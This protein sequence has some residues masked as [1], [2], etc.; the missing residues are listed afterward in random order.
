[1]LDRV[2]FSGLDEVPKASSIAAALH[3]KTSNVASNLTTKGKIQGLTSK[4]L[5]GKAHT[6]KSTL[7]FE[8][9]LAL[10]IYGLVFSPSIDGFVDAKAVQIFLTKNPVPTLLADT[11]HSI[12]HRTDKQGGTILCYA[13]LLYKWYTLHLPRLYLSK[14]KALYS[15]KIMSLAPTDVVWYN[16]TYDIGT[17]IDS[18]G[19]FANVALLGIHGGISYKPTLAKRPFGYP[20]KEKPRNIALES[21]FYH[22]HTDN[23]GM[24]DQFVKSWRTIQKKNNNQ[25]GDKSDLT[26]ETYTQWVIDRAVEYGMPYTL[27]R[28]LSSTTPKLPLPLPPNTQEKYQGK[29]VDLK[30]VCAT[31]KRKY[32]EAMSQVEDRDVEILQHKHELLDKERQLIE[33]NVQIQAQSARLAQFISRKECMDFFAGV[34]PDFEE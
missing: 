16:P 24:R 5:I 29:M 14:E 30:R 22:Y 26:Y 17:I 28:Y 11:Y 1:V 31:W 2:P 19:A 32:E 3:L 13:P 27:P 15:E 7:V 10:L 23:K 25:L 20:M 18:C 8:S 12:H 4:F 34:H 6:C 21:I 33:K 9:I